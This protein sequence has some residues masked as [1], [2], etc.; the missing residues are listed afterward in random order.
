MKFQRCFLQGVKITARWHRQISKHDVY[1]LWQAMWMLIPPISRIVDG[2]QK[3][4]TRLTWGRQ[5]GK[6][7]EMHNPLPGRGPGS[8]KRPTLSLRAT[9]PAAQ[10]CPG[11]TFEF[12]EHTGVFQLSHPPLPNSNYP[13]LF[14]DL[15]SPCSLQPSSSLQPLGPASVPILSL[16][17]Q[18]APSVPSSPLFLTSSPLVLPL[19]PH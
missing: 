14:S 6:Q 2:S 7:M 13:G 15:G 19:C 17:P 12:S 11:K 4:A 18:R 9:P 3:A 8:P 16:G 5:A 1:V 10:P